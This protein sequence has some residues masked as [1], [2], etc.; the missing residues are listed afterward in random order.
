MLFTFLKWVLIGPH[1]S[2]GDRAKQI[3]SIIEVTTEVV[4]QDM[5]SN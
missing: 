1:N 2:D 5:K 4:S 3:E